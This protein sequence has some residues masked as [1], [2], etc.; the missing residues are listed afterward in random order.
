MKCHCNESCI[1]NK[2]QLLNKTERLYSD[3]NDCV[4]KKLKKAMPLKRQ[5]KLDKI[6]AQYGKCPVCNKRNIDYVMA[7]ILKILI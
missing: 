5:V 6:D 1:E 3:C 2:E 4:T 7:H